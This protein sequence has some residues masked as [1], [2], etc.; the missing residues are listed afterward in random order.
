MATGSTART[1]KAFRP[2][3]FGPA[4]EYDEDQQRIKAANLECYIKRAEK[5][6]PIFGSQN[7]SLQDEIKLILEGV[8]A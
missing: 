3:R 1:L 5:G 8:Q 7:R 6:S 4:D 2:S